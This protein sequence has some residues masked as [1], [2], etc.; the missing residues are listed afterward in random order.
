MVLAVFSL[1]QWD[2]AVLYLLQT[3]RPL[4]NR[5]TVKDSHESYIEKKLKKNHFVF[6]KVGKAFF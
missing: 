6:A 3:K 1:A 2:S 5:N 4:M